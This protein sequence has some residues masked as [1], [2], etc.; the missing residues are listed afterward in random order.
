MPSG[1]GLGVRGVQ[2][3]A[4]RTTGREHDLGRTECHY[5]AARFVERLEP[6]A[7]Q[8]TLIEAAR[9]NEITCGFGSWA[10]LSR[11]KTATCS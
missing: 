3:D 7:G 1:G 2:V 8:R 9:R 10:C 6:R 11:S 5:F 4:A